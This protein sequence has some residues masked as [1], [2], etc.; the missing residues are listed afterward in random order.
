MIDDPGLK[1]DLVYGLDISDLDPY[2]PQFQKVTDLICLC[3]LYD[4]FHLWLLPVEYNALLHA[5]ERQCEAA[6][7]P[8]E[9]LELKPMDEGDWRDQL[10]AQREFTQPL[11][12]KK[13]KKMDEVMARQIAERKLIGTG[14]VL[15]RG[16]PICGDRVWRFPVRQVNE[17]DEPFDGQTMVV[18]V[19]VGP[20]DKPH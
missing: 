10:E 12:R 7:V 16:P 11:P 2:S 20:E 5:I 1:A 18:T 14:F 9:S 8:F 4:R 13:S 19:R 6:G 15:R 3:R 17:P